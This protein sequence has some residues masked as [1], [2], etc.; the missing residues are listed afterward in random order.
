MGGHTKE[1]KC[2]GERRTD[3]RD[4]WEHR[5]GKRGK[6]ANSPRALGKEYTDYAK[7]EAAREARL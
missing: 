7:T 5:V 6:N 2:Q 3:W 1:F 4:A